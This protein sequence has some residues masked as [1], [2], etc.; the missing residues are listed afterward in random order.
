MA[1]VVFYDRPGGSG[2]SGQLALLRR[3]GHDVEVRN[4]LTHP[5]TRDEL[6]LFLGEVPVPDWI[7]RT[8]PRVRSGE[9]NPSNLSYGE[10][11]SLLLADPGLLRRPLLEVGTRREVGFLVVVIDRWIGLDPAPP[12]E[13]LDDRRGHG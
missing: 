5:W 13:G 7:D 3:A 9:V 6:L 2:T 10:A 4:T 12:A 1:H 8:S 11:L